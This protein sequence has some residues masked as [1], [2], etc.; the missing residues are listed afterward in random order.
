LNAD[1]RTV[2]LTV[3]T[4]HDDHAVG[5]MIPPAVVMA[6][7]PAVVMATIL[8]DHDGFRAGGRRRRRKG[9]AK[10]GKGGK[11]HNN[12]THASF[13]SGVNIAP[14]T[15]KQRKCSNFVWI[16]KAERLFI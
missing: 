16:F 6:A 12:L 14:S 7:V 9:N 15:P 11:S 1:G 8:L 3:M 10:R 2:V 5:A 13:S 4:L